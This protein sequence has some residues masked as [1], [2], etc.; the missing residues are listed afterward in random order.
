MACYDCQLGDLE[1]A[2]ARLRHAF[3]LGPKFRVC[4]LDDEDL[5]AFPKNTQFFA[6]Q[7]F[8]IAVIGGCLTVFNFSEEPPAEMPDEW[9]FALDPVIE[10]SEVES[11][12][13][14][15]AEKLRAWFAL[16]ALPLA[17]DPKED[18]VLRALM[19]HGFSRSV[20]AGMSAGNARLMLVALDEA[21]KEVAAERDGEGSWIS[22]DDWNDLM[23]ETRRLIVGNAANPP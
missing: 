2:K 11:R 14:V 6:E 19:G 18:A 12:A 21:K 15:D 20:L 1:V 17:G 16:Q 5:K 23:S 8:L 13:R 22:T 7:S 4:A 10:L 3:K 9:F